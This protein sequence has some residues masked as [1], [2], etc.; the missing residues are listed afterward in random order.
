MKRKFLSL[1]VLFLTT[2]AYA[3]LGVGILRPNSSSQ[4]E[5]SSNEKG[6]LIPRVA[7]T[8]IKDATTIKNGN[9][10]SLL[11][12]NTSKT[13]QLSPG[14]Y[15]WYEDRWLRILNSSEL[16]KLLKEDLKGLSF[17]IDGDNLVLID[18]QGSLFGSVK[19]KD[20]NI[21]TTIKNNNNGTYTYTNESGVDVLIDVP[22]S[23]S[24]NFLSIISKS[25]VQ[26]ILNEYIVTNGGNV[27]Y[28]GSS[29]S[30][31]D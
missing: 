30:Y 2:G 22:L 5:V 29:F 21:I 15:Y 1:T 4:L 14:Y 26:K 10:N 18:K 31:T 19:I 13:D 27:K 16:E 11:V 23:V 12:F 28:D 3:Q 20:L 6:I 7:L 25:E 24:N 8:S 17:K 9:V